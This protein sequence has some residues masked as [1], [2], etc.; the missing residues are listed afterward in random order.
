MTESEI[1]TKVKAIL[2]EIGEEASL[3]LL[4][5]DTVKIT[6]YIRSAI[7]DA[8]AYVQLH[9]PVRCVNKKEYSGSS[10]LSTDS[11]GFIRIVLPDDYVQ[12]IAV[13]LSTWKRVATVAYPYDTQEY[14]AQANEYTR[15]GDYKP[16]VVEGW[17]MV[18]SGGSTAAKKTLELT[19]SIAAPTLEMLLYEGKYVSADSG[20]VLPLAATDPIALAVCY[21]T[22]SLVYSYF[23]N[24][25]TA[26]E[27]Q[28]IATALIPQE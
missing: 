9:S 4:A 18:T 2:N 24:K 7:P 14:Y 1:I 3:T 20:D 10:T 22:A 12:L 27:M 11:D 5:Q 6:E 26:D 15:S 23:E 16:V 21:M 8:V 28:R 19:S 25:N 13:K 17:K